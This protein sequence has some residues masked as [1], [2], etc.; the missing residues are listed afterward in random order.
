MYMPEGG[1]WKPALAVW[2]LRPLFFHVWLWHRRS[3]ARGHVLGVHLWYF[4]KKYIFKKCDH[5]KTAIYSFG[6]PLGFGWLC[7]GW[8]WKMQQRDKAQLKR[9]WQKTR[10]NSTLKPATFSD[11]YWTRYLQ[12]TVKITFFSV[13]KPETSHIAAF[14]HDP[15]PTSG[16]GGNR[17]GTRIAYRGLHLAHPLNSHLVRR[18]KLRLAYRL[19]FVT[20]ASIFQNIHKI[21]NNIIPVLPHEAVPEVSKVK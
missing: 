7:L 12:N 13:S 18:A 2:I 10:H 8:T 1:E 4:C 21:E 19:V 5:F 6:S 14:S 11:I 20:Y 3:R 17:S 9:V 15:P 16:P